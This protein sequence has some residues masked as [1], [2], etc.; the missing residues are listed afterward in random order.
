ME[1]NPDQI[2]PFEKRLSELYFKNK[3][4]YKHYVIVKFY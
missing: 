4:K 2:R 1:E 3:N